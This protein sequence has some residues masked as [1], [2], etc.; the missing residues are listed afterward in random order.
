VYYVQ[1]LSPWLD[2]KIILLTPWA[3]WRQDSPGADARRADAANSAP[4]VRP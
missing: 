1:N 3:L 2:L 4:S